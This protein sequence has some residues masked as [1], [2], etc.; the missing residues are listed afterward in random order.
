MTEAV[1]RPRVPLAQAAE[2]AR[3]VLSLLSLDCEQIAVAGS[4]RRQ[5][6]DVG[7]IEIVCI[8]KRGTAPRVVD[9]FT[10]VE[11][12]VDFLHERCRELIV[13]GTFG[14]RVD[15]NGR[16]AFGAKYKRLVCRGFP[17]D[18]FSTDAACWGVIFLLRTGPAEFNQNL[19]LKASQGGWLPRGFFFKDGRLWKLPPPYDA[20]L[21]PYATAL[22]TPEEADVFAS[23]GYEWVPPEERS[24]DR[25]P[26]RI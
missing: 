26:R 4:I 25:K 17:L 15:K 21:A 8:P 13:S 18:V 2:L 11:E 14:H 1:A 9:M 6:P 12:P 3:D 23:L 22:S 24:G 10:T 20:N 5:K 19:V 7:D 16:N